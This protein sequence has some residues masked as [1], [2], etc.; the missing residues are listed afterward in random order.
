MLAEKGV[1]EPLVK[2]AGAGQGPTKKAEK[3]LKPNDPCHC[4]SGKKYKKCCK[5]KDLQEQHQHFF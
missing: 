5:K 1:F 3:K 4:G 2:T